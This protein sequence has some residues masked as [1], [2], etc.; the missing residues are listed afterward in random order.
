MP[1]PPR[2][3]LHVTCGWRTYVVEA[4]HDVSALTTLATLTSSRFFHL[5]TGGTG[6]KDGCTVGTKGA[7]NLCL[8][9]LA[10]WSRC[11]ASQVARVCSFTSGGIHRDQRK[12]VR[13]PPHFKVL[14]HSHSPLTYHKSLKKES[15]GF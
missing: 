7:S 6:S 5:P 15:I 14:F 2:A 3:W 8:H 13:I 1:R 12:A 9:I 11:R 4:F 10:S